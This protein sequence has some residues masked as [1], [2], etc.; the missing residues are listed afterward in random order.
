[1]SNN[2]LQVILRSIRPPFL[3]LTPVCILLG[4]GTAINTGAE[5]NT[6]TFL[7]ALAGA[8]SAH[9]S[10][11]TLNEYLDFRSGLDLVTQKTPFSGGSGALP[12]NPLAASAVLSVAILTLVT[13]ILIGLYFIVLRGLAILP[14]GLM[15]VVIIVLYT[16]WIN[17]HPF[18]CLLAPGLGF[19][20]LMVIGTHF[21]L[22]GNYHWLAAIASL[23]P[24]FLVSNL[25]LLNQY[26]D[27]K[28]DKSV[29][30]RHFP[31]AFGTD[32]SNWTYASFISLT[33]L[34]ILIAVVT[35]LLPKLSLISLLTII[36]AVPT[37]MGVFRYANDTPRLI[38][39]L[40]L[41]VAV[42]LLTPTLLGVSLLAA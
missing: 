34:A 26:P 40:A 7:L 28:A 13:T 14:L 36:V 12:D 20:P 38:P 9:I 16:G 29:G 21:V 37:L 23:I 33:Y 10:V 30:R 15:G 41:N 27:I 4:L 19:G 1:M 42:T 35:G 22:T 6:A 17:R 31:I 3:L 24:L 39:Y 5:I 25:L 11:N 18:S 2:N 32:V 8:I